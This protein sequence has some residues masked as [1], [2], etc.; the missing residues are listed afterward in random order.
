MKHAGI[1]LALWL[2]F[3]PPVSAGSLSE[4][5]TSALHEDI[6]EMVAAF[7]AGDATLLIERTHGSLPA[8][9]GGREVFEQV[10][11]GAMRQLREGG[12]RFVRFEQGEPTTTYPAGEEEVCFVPKYS[13]IDV[14]GKQVKSTSFMIAIRKLGGG[15]WTY[16]DGAG[17][18]SNPELL[19]QLLPKLE[20]GIAMPPNLVEPL[21]E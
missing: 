1:L 16:L 21:A 12:V 10:T 13:V 2:L 14:Q 5:E 17:M 18:R 6:A 15:R 3:A 9:M 8:L 20:R 7:E 11:E 4:A 19:H